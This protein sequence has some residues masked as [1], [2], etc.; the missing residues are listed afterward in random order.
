MPALTTDAPLE[1]SDQELS[2]V[3]R[4][5]YERSGITLHD[6]KRA[7]IMARL[8]KRVRHGGFVSFGEY[9][10]Y[11]RADPSGDEL[12][13]LLDAIATNHTSFFREPQH[14]TFLSDVVLPQ[15][16]GSPINAWSAACSTGEEPYTLAITALEKLGAGARASFKL[17]ASDLSTKALTTAK[18]AVYKS[19]RVESVAPA[20]LKKY[21]EK[22][23]G[24]QDG[25]VRLAPDVRALVEFRRMNLLD[26]PPIDRHFHFIFCRNVMIYFDAAVRQRVVSALERRLHPQ[27]YLFIAHSESLNG[28]SHRMKWIAPAVYRRGDAP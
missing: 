25:L 2:A 20:L 28:I 23:L 9:L 21:F 14:F 12:T 17:I 18:G 6:G 15:L 13:T 11:V 27:G 3:I 10:K 4:L 7:L 19:D 16:A 24:S 1:L 5:V 22:G 8:Q 26:L